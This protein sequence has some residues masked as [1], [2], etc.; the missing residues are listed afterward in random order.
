[1]VIFSSLPNEIKDYIASLAHVHFAILY[2]KQDL[3]DY[4]FNK[5]N[6]LF[7]M[8]VKH[9]DIDTLKYIYKNKSQMILYNSLKDNYSYL[10]RALTN[11]LGFYSD[12]FDNYSIIRDKM[13]DYLYEIENI[14]GSNA[15]IDLLYFSDDPDITRY[16]KAIIRLKEYYIKKQI[17]LAY[18]CNYIRIAE[19]IYN[20][21][22][23][24]SIAINIIRSCGYYMSKYRFYTTMVYI[25]KQG[26][27]YPHSPLW[28]EMVIQCIRHCNIDALSLFNIYS[29]EL[30]SFL[31]LHTYA[32][33]ILVSD[34]RCGENRSEKKEVYTYINDIL[35]SRYSFTNT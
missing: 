6:D 4:H 12:S 29:L 35:L 14:Y 30:D 28:Y 32:R 21:D 20:N 10:L 7:E 22:K 18:E 2:K 19:F 5:R 3:I 25:T 26:E 8:A 24:L 31:R 33:D 16:R 13:L 17:K 1:M 27:Y 15:I 9:N 34:M 23:S 11:G